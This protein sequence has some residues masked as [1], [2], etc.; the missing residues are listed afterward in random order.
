MESIKLGEVGQ[1]DVVGGVVKISAGHSAAIGK[2]NVVVEVP[3]IA[4]L[5]VA[6]AKSDNK[7]DDAMVAMLKV[8]IG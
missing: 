8:A 6:A 2:I 5:E 7:I 3:L 4:L 1:I